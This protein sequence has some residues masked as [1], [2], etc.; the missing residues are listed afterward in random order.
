MCTESPFLGV[1]AHIIASTPFAVAMMMSSTPTFS[2]NVTS[3]AAGDW[4]NLSW[5]NL[6]PIS[7]LRIDF[8]V[9]DDENHRWRLEPANESTTTFW[10]GEFSPPVMSKNDVHMGDNPRTRVS[11]YAT[12]GTPPF[13]QPAPVKFISGAQLTKHGSSWP[14]RVS[15]HRS[16]INWVL[17]AGSL[18][19]PTGFEVLAISPTVS[20]SD[21][22]APM[23]V[24]LA[25][26][27]SPDEM[28][29]SW[30]SAQ[31]DGPHQVQYGYSAT[32]L[33][34]VAQATTHTY[35]RGDLCGFPA[36]ESGYHD[37][38]YHHETVLSLRRDRP[39]GDVVYYRA[40]SPAHGFSPVRYFTAPLPPRDAPPKGAPAA[41]SLVVAADMGET[42]RDGAQYHWEEPS[43]VNTTAHI[44]RLLKRLGGPG[45]DLVFHPGDLAYATGYG[46][47]WD[48]FM[49]QIE[50]ISAYV[51][52]MTAFGN[53]E[54]DF[55][56]SGAAIGR[57]DSGG[58]CGVPT[59]ARFHM[60]TCPQPNTAPCVGHPAA[61]HSGLNLRPGHAQRRL[62][63]PVGSADD[64]WYSFDQGPVHFAVMNTEMSS[65]V[66][67]R[68][69]AFFAADLAA[70][71]RSATPWVLFMGHRQMYCN[72]QA[73]SYDPKYDPTRPANDLGD[74]EPLLLQHKVDVAFWGHI[75]FAERSCP[76]FN[77]TCV[78]R[79]DASGYDAPIHAV[80][81][82]AGQSLSSFSKSPAAWSV[83][84]AA[85]WGFSHVTVHNDTHLTLDYYADAPLDAVAPLHHSVTLERKYPRV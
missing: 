79:R 9:D 20:L 70:V 83:Y 28:R 55:P 47:E 46:S 2:V 41:L 30:T 8:F 15:N 10:I 52:Y 74:I 69:H 5:S 58:E 27:S 21:A 53:H 75:H 29:V 64:G 50:P 61:A 36:N 78:T 84:R 80:I 25:R 71:D 40:G 65:R 45:L 1:P 49:E 44:A 68:Q 26:T 32:A 31:P 72:R 48:R 37:P 17:F 73:A 39:S 51:P 13:T 54:R 34:N 62:S 11:G 76:M 6:G 4:V 19:S 23:H 35:T 7:D 43:A 57:G 77:G 60:P 42:Y 24:R 12:E 67:S 18:T 81:G 85:E 38:G 56:N 22:A 3:V 16:S 33:D 14:F 59:Q 63:S 82:N 66:G